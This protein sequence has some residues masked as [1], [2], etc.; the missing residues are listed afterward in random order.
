MAEVLVVLDTH[1]LIEAI[2]QLKPEYE[3]A[4]NAMIERHHKLL[5]SNRI[6]KQYQ[7]IIHQRYN[8]PAIFLLRKLQD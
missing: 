4:Y 3:G 2:L 6:L 5:I 7:T 8:Y 1:I